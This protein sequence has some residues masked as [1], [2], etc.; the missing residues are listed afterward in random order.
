MTVKTTGAISW[1][2]HCPDDDIMKFDPASTALPDT[3]AQPANR[4][5]IA[6]ILADTQD[7]PMCNSAV[8]LARAP[9][10]RR[11]QAESRW[12]RA[13][14]GRF[15]WKCWS[16][17]ACDVLQRSVVR[18]SCARIF[19][20]SAQRSCSYEGGAHPHTSCLF[21]CSMLYSSLFG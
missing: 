7:D 14:R 4:A 21:I 13:A 18:I 9:S 12:R 16:G 1:R 8:S 3:S 20:T 2:R 17:L 11:A 15:H 6:A 19:R 10:V 5:A